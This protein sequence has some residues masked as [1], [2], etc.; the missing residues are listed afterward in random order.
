MNGPIQ[1]MDPW[2]QGV[3]AA[4][5]PIVEE[6]ELDPFDDPAVKDGGA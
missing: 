2:A 6:V 1:P 3:R 4:D 5:V